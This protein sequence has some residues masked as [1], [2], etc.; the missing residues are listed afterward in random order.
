M[1]NAISKRKKIIR[2]QGARLL[3]LCLRARKPGERL[4][5][6]FAFDLDNLAWIDLSIPIAGTPPQSR[7]EPGFAEAGGKLYV[8]GGQGE[9]GAAEIVRGVGS[10]AACLSLPVQRRYGR[11]WDS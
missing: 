6:L 5:D 1:T 7:S 9:T 4:N 2:V 8:H 11:G 10:L 3:A